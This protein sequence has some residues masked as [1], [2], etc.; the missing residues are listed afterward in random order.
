M[1]KTVIRRF[2]YYF[3]LLRELVGRDLKVRYKRS[4]LG[5]AWSLLNPLL[6]LLVF[7]FVFRFFIPLRIPDYTLFLFSGIL[8]WSWFQSSLSSATGAIVDNPSLLRQP[9]FPSSL[10]PAVSVMSNT[11]N[12]ILALPVLLIFAWARGHLPNLSLVALPLVMA[13]QFLL[14]LGVAYFLAM[15]HVPFRDTQ[16]MLGIML[17]LGFYMVPIVYDAAAIPI[18]YQHIYRLNPLVSIVEAY[19]SIILHGQTPHGLPLLLTG[20]LSCALLLL[21]RIL[22]VRVSYSFLEEL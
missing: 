1:Q 9:G 14:T 15:L 3:D 21:G 8:V 22:F 18:K 13:I 11:V 12:F 2:V 16:Y 6:Q 10:L 7:S 5:M 20:L 4:V 17:F 19:R